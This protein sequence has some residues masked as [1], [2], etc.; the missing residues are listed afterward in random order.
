[1]QPATK[2]GMAMWVEVVAARGQRLVGAVVRRVSSGAK[3][4]ANGSCSGLAVSSMFA[5][6]PRQR[7]RLSDR[8]GVVGART[9]THLRSQ[10]DR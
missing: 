9:P 7:R 5:Q 4:A 1:M 3:R 2:S 10:E 6:S 8:M